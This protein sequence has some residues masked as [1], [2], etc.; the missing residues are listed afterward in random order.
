MWTSVNNWWCPSLLSKTTW[1]HVW[2]QPVDLEGRDSTHPLCFVLLFVFHTTVYSD[3]YTL[4][5]RRNNSAAR[6]Q[7]STCWS[8]AWCFRSH[9]SMSLVTCQVWWFPTYSR[10]EE[11]WAAHEQTGEAYVNCTWSNHWYHHSARSL[12][13]TVLWIIDLPLIPD[14][15][16]PCLCIEMINYATFVLI[17]QLKM[18]HILCWNHVFYTTPSKISFHHNLRM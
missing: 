2:G 4:K 5:L 6:R 15:G 13:L 3:T 11:D 7:G 14:D 17:T 1:H 9:V 12:L 16:W 18:G 8:F 10:K